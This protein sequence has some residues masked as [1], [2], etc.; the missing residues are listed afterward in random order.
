L[1][2]K[3]LLKVCPKFNSLIKNG[4][5]SRKELEQI[6]R[7]I[8]QVLFN[9]NKRLAEERNQYQKFGVD[10]TSCCLKLENKRVA[11]RKKPA[12]EHYSNKK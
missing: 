5:A 7:E 6:E 10:I 4:E 11:V 3:L 1:V 12:R 2:E 8:S 9:S